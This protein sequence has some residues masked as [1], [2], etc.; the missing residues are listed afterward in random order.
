M[1]IHIIDVD[2]VMVGDPGGG[3][4][5]DPDGRRGGGR[6]GGCGCEHDG[7]SGGGCSLGGER[8]FY[9]GGFGLCGDISGGHM[10]WGK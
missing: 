2:Q 5:G 6:G 1:V 4:G 10:R 3:L 9:R 8:D 7:D